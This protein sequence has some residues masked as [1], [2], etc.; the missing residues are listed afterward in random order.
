MGS[1]TANSKHFPRYELSH[2]FVPKELRSNL[3]RV[4]PVQSPFCPEAAAFMLHICIH[5]IK[6]FLPQVVSLQD[7][8]IVLAVESC[9][10]PDD[11]VLLLMTWQSPW[12]SQLCCATTTVSSL[13]TFGPYMS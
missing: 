5:H 13:V 1:P 12:G 2:S 3:I 9:F 7:F 6:F 10:A 4:C 8:T 11:L